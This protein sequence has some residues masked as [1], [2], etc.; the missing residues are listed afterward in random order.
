MAR[1][2]RTSCKPQSREDQHA[3]DFQRDERMERR[4]G[5]ENDISWYSKYPNL[6]L[7]AGSFPYPYRPGMQINLGTNQVPVTLENGTNNLVIPGVMA[8]DWCPSF[9]KSQSATDP[10]SIAAKEWYARV[11]RA[12]SGALDADAPDFMMYLGALDSVFSYIAWLKR[13]YRVMNVWT[14]ENYALPNVVLNAM[15]LSTQDIESLRT[16]RVQLW[17][18]INELVYQSRKFTCPAVMDVFNR[19]YWMSDNVYTDDSMINSQF[20][21]FNLKY[22]YHF[23]MLPTVQGDEGPGLEM[24]PMPTVRQYVQGTPIKYSELYE[25]GRQLIDDLVAWDEAY[26]I[27]G[28]L[29][30]AFDGV[31]SFIV[32]ELPQ[33]QPF[34]PVYVPEVLAQIEN[35]RC[36]VSGWAMTAALMKGMNVTQD[37]LKNCVICNPAF[38]Y[39]AKRTQEQLN[40]A[41]V[42]PTLSIRSQTPTVADSVIASRLQAMTSFDV[43]NVNTP[44][45]YVEAGTELPLG[46]R[47]LD[48]VLEENLSG[49]TSVFRSKSVFESVWAFTINHATTGG[50]TI[51]TVA[52]KFNQFLPIF[53]AE[54]FDWHPF[55]FVQFAEAN[56]NPQGLIQFAVSGDTHNLTTVLPEDLNNLHKVCLYSEFNA[57][58]I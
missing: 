42:L 30:R 16:D 35:S 10:I 3:R 14:P 18:V 7:A 28:Y 38:T 9:G 19:H 5:S 39:A 20:Y 37:V 29:Q 22:L 56:V 32:D 58:S 31:P 15:G 21:L 36:V 27:N 57:F 4:N 25:F 2:R 45:M 48:G 6:L 8:L 51:A 50:D 53:K 54:Q 52:A 55:A 40:A 26:T 33:D 17:Q 43:T 12:F 13:L 23:K 11:R 44:I 34:N 1:K 41:N 47:L 24:I 46:W 49:N